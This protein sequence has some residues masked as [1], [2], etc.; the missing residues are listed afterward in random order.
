MGSLPAEHI[1]PL[2]TIRPS[3]VAG[4]FYPANAAR[5]EVDVR[6]YLIDADAPEDCEDYPLVK[7]IIAPHAGYPYSGPVAASAYVHLACTDIPVKRFVL[8]GPA[9]FAPVQ[10]I[11]VSSAAAFDTPLGRVPVDDDGRAGALSLPGVSIDDDAH[12]PEHCLEVQL[13]FLQELF[14]DF[15]IIPLL[16][17]ETTVEAVAAVLEALWD[18][19]E[20]RIVVSSDLSHYHD[21][22]MARQLDEETAAAIVGLRPDA[23]REDSACGRAAIAGLLTVAR[24]HGLTA[25]VADL[26]NSG[27]T[28]GPRDR[29]VGYGAF[30][31]TTPA[32][33]AY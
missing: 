11:A 20:T 24:G 1:M 8:L 3:I 12:A 10:G 15:S 28:G 25:Q 7:A 22:V 18:G 9:H 19:P 31:F 30:L 23:L 2:N 27:D 13:P 5:L 16:V 29:V 32:P 4:R 14:L 17:G 33:P 21:H 6:R 26:G